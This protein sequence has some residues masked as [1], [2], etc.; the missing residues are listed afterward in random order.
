MQKVCVTF[1][2]QLYR[3][4]TI[5][6]KCVLTHLFSRDVFPANHICDEERDLTHEHDYCVH[7]LAMVT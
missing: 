6:I 3:D 5:W 7:H 2:Y 1:Y 4:N